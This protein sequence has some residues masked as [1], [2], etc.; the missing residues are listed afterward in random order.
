MR[1]QMALELSWKETG[2]QLSVDCTYK[3]TEVEQS[4]EIRGSPERTIAMLR[5]KV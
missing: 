5:C 3:E 2:L 1:S 4:S